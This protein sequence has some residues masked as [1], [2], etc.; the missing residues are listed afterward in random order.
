MELK[1]I[2]EIVRI[3]QEIKESTEPFARSIIRSPEDAQN[4]AASYIADEDREV[5]L[6]IVLSTK[7]EVIAVHRAHVGSINA[8][9]VSPR[10]VFKSAILNNGKS[11]IFSHNH[12]SGID[13]S[14]S[15]ED[16]E[17]TKRLAEV[18]RLLDIEVLDHVIVT[19][20]GK[21]TSLKEKGY[22]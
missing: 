15:R 22:L 21:H 9:I 16:I 11:V 10:D 20:N 6:V 4:L 12:P 7:N 3:K 2:F 17:V 8:S 18:G 5:F 1:P 13:S 14:P 19:Y